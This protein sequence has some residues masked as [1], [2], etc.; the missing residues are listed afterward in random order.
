MILAELDGELLIMAQ[1]LYEAGLQVSECLRLRVKEIDF[2][3]RLFLVR[4]GKGQKDVRTTMIY[5]HVAKR[6][7]WGVRSPLDEIL[8]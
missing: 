2:G 5:T 6:A 3:Q 7:L 1:L 4:D 8:R